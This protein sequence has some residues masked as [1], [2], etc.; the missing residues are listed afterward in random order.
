MIVLKDDIKDLPV[1]HSVIA[2]LEKRGR[3]RTE[4]YTF[5][6]FVNGVPRLKGK[7]ETKS[8]DGC[9][10]EFTNSFI[11]EQMENYSFTA[12]THK[13]LEAKYKWSAVKDLRRSVEDA[14]I[15]TTHGLMETNDRTLSRLGNALQLTRTTNWTTK[16]NQVVTLNPTKIKRVLEEIG[17]GLERIHAVS[18]ALR[19]EVYASNDPRT[20]DIDARWAYY[21][22]NL[23]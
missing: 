11:I 22:Q 4:E 15:L 3:V 7:T 14:G 19:V 23:P 5:E 17:V 12:T 6:G 10:I 21:T 9:E 2:K 18:Q 16:D 20:I 1:G 8:V 13:P